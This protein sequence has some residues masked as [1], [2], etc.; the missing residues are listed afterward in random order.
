MAEIQSL[1]NL[2]LE[3]AM[4]L[5]DIKIVPILTYGLEI[6]WERLGENSLNTLESMKATNLNMALRVSRYTTCS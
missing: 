6:L 2:L 3:T 1:S 4:R 5:F